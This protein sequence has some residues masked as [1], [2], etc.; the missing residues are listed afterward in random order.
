[1]LG[2]FIEFIQRAQHDQTARR[3]LIS[4]KAGG[5]HDA[6]KN[7]PVVDLDHIVATLDAERL[8]RIRRQH[9]NLGICRDAVGANR[10]GIELHELAIAP[11]ARLLVAINRAISVTPE[12]F[13][14]PVEILRHVTR[15][16]RRQIIA[17]AHPLIGGCWLALLGSLI[18]RLRHGILKRE[19]TRVRAILIRQKLTQRVGIFERRRFQGLKTITLIDAADGFQH[20]VEGFELSRFNVAESFGGARFWPRV[21]L[22][23]GHII[24]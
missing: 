5:F 1:M 22:V 24:D 6:V 11:R 10:I 14:Q 19:H 9:A 20:G 3:K 23:I 2:K 17:Q 16:W 7:L 13:R 8:E 4:R 15:Q 12:R 21:G 18:A